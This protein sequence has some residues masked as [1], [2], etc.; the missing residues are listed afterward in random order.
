VRTERKELASKLPRNI[1]ADYDRILAPA[2]GWPW[3]R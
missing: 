1:L 2:P 3:S